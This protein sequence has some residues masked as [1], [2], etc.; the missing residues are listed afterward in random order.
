MQCVC[1]VHRRV[2]AGLQK[3]RKQLERD[4]RTSC[5]WVGQAHVTRTQVYFRPLHSTSSFIS[6]PRPQS[7][8]SLPSSLRKPHK[9][10]DCSKVQSELAG[11]RCI[12]T[13]HCSGSS[14]NWPIHRQS[15]R[16]SFAHRSQYRL[17]FALV[18]TRIFSLETD[19]ALHETPTR[20]VVLKSNP[21][22]RLLREHKDTRRF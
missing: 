1:V 11:S 22:W 5:G 16:H 7:P 18:I 19:L 21:T 12:W 9:K 8:F 20:F 14:G 17:Y 13:Q 4:A 6:S 3:L 2:G 15:S 10:N